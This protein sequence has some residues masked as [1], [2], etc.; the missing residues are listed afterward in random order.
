[1]QIYRWEHEGQPYNYFQ[2][3]LKLPIFHMV[4]KCDNSDNSIYKGVNLS[5]DTSF[6]FRYTNNH[7]MLM[8]RI[9]GFGI[10]ALRQTDY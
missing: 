2:L 8:V 9:L 7:W 6:T 1:M 10:A 5:F 3:L 4:N